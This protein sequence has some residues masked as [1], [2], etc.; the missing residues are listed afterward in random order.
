MTF[1]LPGG[2]FMKLAE[3]GSMRCLSRWAISGVDSLSG[4]LEQALQ[5]HFVHLPLDGCGAA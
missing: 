2:R 4:L 3:S 1:E 5:R